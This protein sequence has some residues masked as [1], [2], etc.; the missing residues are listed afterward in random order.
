[1]FVAKQNAH[2]LYEETEKSVTFAH[3]KVQQKL[4]AF[5]PGRPVDPAAH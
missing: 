4:K 5:A 1:M 2:P 3:T